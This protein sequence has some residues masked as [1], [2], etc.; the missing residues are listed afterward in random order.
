MTENFPHDLLDR[1]IFFL[2]NILKTIPFVSMFIH[3]LYIFLL[4]MKCNDVI[5]KSMTAMIRKK[6]KNK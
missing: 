6:R 5:V 3:F 4:C 1:L 2:L